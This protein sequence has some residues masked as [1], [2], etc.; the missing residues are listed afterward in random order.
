MKKY[1]DVLKIDVNPYMK[2]IKRAYMIVGFEMTIR[3]LGIY[4]KVRKLKG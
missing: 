2:F 1:R 3:L 4:D